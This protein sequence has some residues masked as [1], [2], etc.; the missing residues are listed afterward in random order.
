M[1]IVYA[2]LSAIMFV[3]AGLQFNDPDSIHWVV[4]YLVPAFALA[5]AAFVPQW[6]CTIIGRIIL[7]VIIV[8][9]GFG[10]FK[11][12]PTQLSSMLVAQWWDQESVTEGF[13]IAIAYLFTCLT[14][15]LAIRRSVRRLKQRAS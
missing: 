11:F 3:F 2:L 10:V 15:P 7:I 13:G 5:L 4:V 14:I 1:T 12:W 6:F 9:L 8:V